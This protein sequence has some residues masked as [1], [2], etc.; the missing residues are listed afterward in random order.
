MDEVAQ[1]SKTAFSGMNSLQL[2][3]QFPVN[4]V[5]RG[6]IGS[7]SLFAKKGFPQDLQYQTGKGMPKYR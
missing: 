3:S 1:V 5:S 4:L 7:C 6:L 2:Q